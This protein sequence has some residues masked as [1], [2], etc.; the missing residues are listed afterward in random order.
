MP[1]AKKTTKTAPAK[2]L[3][4]KARPLK[5]MTPRAEKGDSALM[6]M[7]AKAKKKK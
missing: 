2:S 7:Q 1:Y 4:P 6:R 5:D 3:R